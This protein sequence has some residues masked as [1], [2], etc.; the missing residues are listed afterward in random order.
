MHQLHQTLQENRWIQ[1]A[2][3]V[4]ISSVL[5]KFDEIPTKKVVGMLSSEKKFVGN[6]W[7]VPTKIREKPTATFP[8][9]NWQ[10][11]SSWYTSSEICHTFPI[12]VII[13][14][15][16][17][18]KYIC[19][20]FLTKHVCREPQFGR[21]CM[22]NFRQNMW[23]NYSD[24]HVSVGSFYLLLFFYKLYFIKYLFFKIKI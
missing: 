5:P 12:G 2:I 6:S 9:D 11:L 23:S 8:M 7:Q 14:K 22:T 21:N 16:I 19:R 15:T 18:T 20:T 17:P 10:Y 24:A 1:T 4:G 13:G 3:F